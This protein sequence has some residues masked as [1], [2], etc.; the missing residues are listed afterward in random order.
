MPLEGLRPWPPL[1]VMTPVCAPR[2]LLAARL[3]TSACSSRGAW[4]KVWVL[5]SQAGAVSRSSA[6]VLALLG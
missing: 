2:V 6:G 3:P 1:Q 4:G 5:Q